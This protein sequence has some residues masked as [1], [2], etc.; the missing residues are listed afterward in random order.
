VAVVTCPVWSQALTRPDAVAAEHSGGA[1]SYLALHRRAQALVATLSD[2]GVQQGQVI[3]TV[4]DNCVELVVLAIACWR[5]GFIWA[6]FNPRWRGDK[7]YQQ[8]L[9]LAP[10]WVWADKV[11]QAILTDT[12]FK[13]VDIS[14]SASSSSVAGCSTLNGFDCCDADPEDIDVLRP[15]DLLQT[16]GSSGQPKFVAHCLHN[17]LCNAK[18]SSDIITVNQ[19]D[20]WLLSLPL[21]HIAGMAI[22][23]RCF[24]AGARLVLTSKDGDLPGHVSIGRVTHVSLV[25]AQLFDL[26]MALPL[27]KSK[28]KAVLLGGSAINKA[29]IAE[30]ID[31]GVPCYSSYGMTEA[32]SQIY[33]I[34]HKKKDHPRCQDRNEYKVVDAPKSKGQILAC[35]D[36]TLDEGSQILL[37]GD[38]LALGYWQQGGVVDFREQDG[39]F[40]TGDIGRWD[41]HVL[42]ITGRRDNAFICGG[43]N[44]QPE[45]IERIICAYPAVKNALVVPVADAKWGQIPIAL[46]DWKREQREG[47]DDW[48]GQRVNGLQRPR[49]LMPWRYVRFNN[50]KLDR[51]ATARIVGEL[52]AKSS[53]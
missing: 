13:A 45:S 4:A 9:E 38:A 12:P 16:S 43:E 52:I 47:L 11:S 15:F 53:D 22:L 25:N 31:A 3:G 41:G 37:K 44:L 30:A 5:A 17:H 21:Y 42:T 18:A 20:G 46:I 49:Q 35:I 40:Q 1:V 7:I 23:F 39:W 33:T 27:P 50:N 10:D 6:P 28:L 36:V 24:N 51:R 14:Y 48:L 19:D 8:L 2:Q 29:A 32:S 34:R 26:L